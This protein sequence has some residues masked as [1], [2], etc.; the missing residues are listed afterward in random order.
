GKTT[1]LKQAFPD[2]VYLDLLES[3]LYNRLTASP[4]SLKRLIPPKCSRCVVIDEVQRVPDLLNEVH[5]LIEA[6]HLRFVLTG[7]SARSLRKKGGNLL[8]GRALT[9]HFHPLTVL[10]L[11]NDFHL[12]DSLQYGHLPYVFSAQNKKDYLSSY[13]RT[14]LREE[15]L[16]EG[17][18]RSLSAFSR[19]LEVASFSQ[20]GLVN[21]SEI[22]RETGVDRKTVENYFQITEDLLIGQRLQSFTKRSRRRLVTGNKFFFFDCGVFRALR[23]VGPLDLVEEVAG[24]ALETLV[25]Q[26]LRA[27]NDYFGLNLD[28]RYWRTATGAEVD[29]VLYGEKGFAAIEVKRTRHLKAS[30]F[31]GLKLFMADYPQAKGYLVCGVERREYVHGIEVWPVAEFLRNLP[32]LFVKDRTDKDQD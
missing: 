27:L 29:F 6:E 8:A 18:T 20:A 25:F 15:V 21:A 30:D 17:L 16:Q 28:I 2:A 23:P 12:P 32:S 10:E 9:C 4:G 3:D 31:S 13:I 22:A 5:R 19:F 11:G 14:Y 24:A 1:W 26:E 7:S